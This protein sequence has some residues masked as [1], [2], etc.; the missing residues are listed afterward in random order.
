[1]GFCLHS[2]T[3]AYRTTSAEATFFTR[4]RKNSSPVTEAVPSITARKT[5][6]AR[7]SNAG[8][9]CKG[10]PPLIADGPIVSL[11]FCSWFSTAEGRTPFAQRKRFSAYRVHLPCND[12]W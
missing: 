2:V 10:P 4:D 8:I 11:H 6:S 9:G 7:D 5:S 1:M 3:N 12:V